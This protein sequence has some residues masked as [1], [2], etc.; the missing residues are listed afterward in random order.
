MYL[1]GSPAGASVTVVP[2]CWQ[3]AINTIETNVTSKHTYFFIGS[4]FS[5]RVPQSVKLRLNLSKAP[6]LQFCSGGL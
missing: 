5:D 3:A 4:E 2:S 6:R 1:A